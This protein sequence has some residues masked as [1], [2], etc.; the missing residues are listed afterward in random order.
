[1]RIFKIFSAKLD[2]FLKTRSSCRLPFSTPVTPSGR[3]TPGIP[4]ARIPASAL[5]SP[6]LQ[7]SPTRESHDVTSAP[8]TRK[9]PPKSLFPFPLIFPIFFQIFLLLSFPSPFP[10]RFLLFS[11]SFLPPL[12]RGSTCTTRPYDALPP[13]ARRSAARR[14]LPTHCVRPATR[15]LPTARRHDHLYSCLPRPVTYRA[16]RHCKPSPTSRHHSL[17]PLPDSHSTT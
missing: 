16:Q 11:Y 4:L 2:Q 17:L 10:F 6:A 9:I 5:D 12:S 13:S 8:E 15:P 3:P 7:S 14:P 1:M